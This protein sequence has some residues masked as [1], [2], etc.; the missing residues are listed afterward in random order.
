MP[1]PPLERGDKMTAEPTILRTEAEEALLAAFDAAAR[2]LPGDAR[3]AAERKAAIDHF[4]RTGLPHRRIEEWK[5]TDLRALM[6]R[7]APLASD[8]QTAPSVK[9]A[10]GP[11]PLDGFDRA[12]IVIVNGV[13]DAS[14]SDHE[15]AEGVTITPLAEA[16]AKGD[17]RIG[18]LIDEGTNAVLS[19]NTAFMAGGVLIEIADGA[20]PPRPFEIIHVVTET[21]PVGVY[22]RNVVSVGRG[23][24]VRIVECHRGP[25][26]V[27]YQTNVVTELTLHEDAHAIWAKLQTE[28]DN[29]LH[30]GT[31]VTRLERNAVLDHLTISAGAAASRSQIFMAIEG[32]G[33]RASLNGTTMIAGT[34]HADL[35]LGIDHLAPNAET[36]VLYK[37]VARDRATGAF[38]GKIFV[39]RE[40][41]KTD[42]KMMNRAL[43]L[44]EEASFAAKPELEIWADDVTCGHGST[45]GRIDEDMLFYFLSRGIPRA[46]AERLLVIA[47]LS[48]SI[49]AL[50]DP[51]LVAALEPA[52]ER[53][54]ASAPVPTLAAEAVT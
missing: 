20:R 52:V 54:L 47:F 43:L 16:L 1:T 25:V 32:E 8:P 49:E 30:V 44:S 22:V 50:G 37:N 15:D 35:T 6:R 21:R 36:R 19:L 18:A 42:A 39:H 7:A 29:A 17:R 53:W 2:R 12:P 34:Q 38:Q 10:P 14:M 31:L 45:S 24:S 3:I 27:A 28:G 33:A 51:E 46:E 11:D 5:Y 40:A 26:E 4:R 9:T 23:A 48:E 41:Q 13:F